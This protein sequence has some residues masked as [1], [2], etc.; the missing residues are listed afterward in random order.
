[1]TLTI[2]FPRRDVDSPPLYPVADI[3]LCWCCF[4]KRDDLATTADPRVGGGELVTTCGPCYHALA[5]DRPVDLPSG[6]ELAELLIDW[7]RYDHNGQVDEDFTGRMLT[8][9]IPGLPETDRNCW[10]ECLQGA[11][12]ELQERRGPGFEL[13]SVEPAARDVDR[14]EA[15]SVGKVSECVQALIGGAR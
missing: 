14:L 8:A 6:D 5:Q 9:L 4:C 11:L 10:F 1:M 13:A 12:L 3:D 7:A 2:P 15:D